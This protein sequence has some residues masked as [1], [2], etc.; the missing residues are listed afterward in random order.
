MRSSK[1]LLVLGSVVAGTSAFGQVD[2][3]NLL[4]ASSGS[5]PVVMFGPLYDSF[6]VGPTGVTV[7]SVMLNVNG[8]TDGLSFTVGIYSDMATSPGAL[9]NSTTVADQTGIV[10]A[11]FGATALSAN[12]RYWI[13]LSDPTG[14]SSETWN[15]SFDTSG[16]GVA[17]EYFAN[18]DGVFPNMGGPYQMAITSTPEPASFAVLGLGVVPLLLRRRRK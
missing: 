2:Y 3:D 8:F 14:M 15:W 16:P 13:G 17:S 11:N 6:S 5:D 10:T 18:S 9:L 12:T 1:L 7:S 4:A